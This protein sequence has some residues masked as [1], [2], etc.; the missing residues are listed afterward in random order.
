MSELLEIRGLTDAFLAM[1]HLSHRSHSEKR[2]L[3]SLVGNFNRVDE[4]NK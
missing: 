3:R 4:A 2:R 1:K